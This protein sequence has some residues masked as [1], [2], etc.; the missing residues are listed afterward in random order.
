MMNI[1]L[2][3]VQTLN[4]ELKTFWFKPQQPLT[5]IAGQFIEIYLPH[6]KSDN[7]G[8]KRWFTLSSSP[9]EPLISITTRFNK[10]KMSSFKQNLLL[11]QPKSV[12][13]I[14][15]PMGDFVLPKDTKIP[16]L[17]VAGGIG[18]TPFRSIIKWL[19]DTDQKRQIQIILA[20]KS[21]SD[22]VFLDIFKKYQLE[23]ILISQDSPKPSILNADIILDTYQTNN[24]NTKTIYLSGPEGMI[25]SL[26]VDL[27]KLN[28]KKEQIVSDY[29]PGYTQI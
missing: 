16:L 26:N 29:F 22:F 23:P 9:S 27:L 15:E 19:I 12:I 5:Y 25:E 10:V 2:D 17:F 8:Q 13:T 20:A 7:R 14:S 3:H 21:T 18:V 1:V 28:I 11:L 6:D 4:A 24:L